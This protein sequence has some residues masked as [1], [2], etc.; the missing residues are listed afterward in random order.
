MSQFE[1]RHQP[2]VKLNKKR[3][4]K[5]SGTK[6]T[7]IPMSADA[8]VKPRPK[9]KYSV[10]RKVPAK[11]SMVITAVTAG[12]LLTIL[13][14]EL[15]LPTGII[16]SIKNGY[17]LI[18][19]EGSGT[20]Y[21]MGSSFLQLD[22]T[23]GRIDL[24]SNNY[25][26][27]YN[28]KGETAYSVQH[29]YSDPVMTSSEARTLIYDRS[30]NECKIYNLRDCLGTYSFDGNIFTADI[31]RNGSFAVAH[32]SEDAISS[33]EVF[34][35]N[36]SLVF[37]QN[38][39]E[40]YVSSL[41][42]NPSGKFLAVTTLI[43][44]G[45]I[46]HSSVYFYNVKKDSLITSTSFDNIVFTASKSLGSRNFLILS[47]DKAFTFNCPKGTF[48]EISITEKI[49]NFAVS[50]NGNFAF[51]CN[52][53][54]NVINNTVRIYDKNG[55]KLK[56][57]TFDGTISGFSLSND[58]LFCLSD[59]TLNRYSVK[60]LKHSSQLFDNT[61]LLTAVNDTAVGIANSK[62]KFAH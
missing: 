18:S 10:V 44:R 16:E 62:L 47:Y 14:F 4:N 23:Y 51:V 31:A 2:K 60:N 59:G 39:S 54:N 52:Q 13:V 3:Q 30:G 1:K 46:I 12:I 37:S 36:G 56:E 19:A 9:K 5:V 26:E 24:L 53:S 48:S 35:K 61:Q 22:G 40:E 41:V 8:A 20:E 57:F 55:K 50:K 32:R 11:K 15:A 58:Y 49:S 27:V 29:G 25:Y 21:L 42:L 6:P 28:S 7:K 38:Y 17:A 34:D 33:V 45:G 43:S